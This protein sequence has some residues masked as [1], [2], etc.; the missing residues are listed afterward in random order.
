GWGRDHSGR[1]MNL[2]P[3]TLLGLVGHLTLTVRRRGSSA[4][5]GPARLGA[6][7]HWRADR[8]RVGR[9]PVGQICRAS[10]TGRKPPMMERV[11]A[12]RVLDRV[13]LAPSETFPE[14]VLCCRS[15][16][17]RARAYQRDEYPN[18]DG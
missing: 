11:E 16:R 7:P 14:D 17:Q 2:V 3:E 9:V 13:D 4:N 10:A 5:P 15:T 12:L 1:L 18:D 8:E 6:R